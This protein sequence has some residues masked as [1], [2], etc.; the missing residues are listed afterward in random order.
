LCLAPQRKK[1]KKKKKRKK[2][3]LLSSKKRNGNLD[4]GLVEK[5]ECPHFPR[6][7]TDFLTRQQKKGS[8]ADEFK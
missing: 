8:L 6:R 2:S 4:R 5:W 3:P 7:E 1:Q